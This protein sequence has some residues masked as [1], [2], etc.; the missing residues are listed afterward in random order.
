MTYEIMKDIIIVLVTAILSMGGYWVT[1]GSSYTTKAE[2]TAMFIENQ[3]F[4][5]I[6]IDQLV[7]AR[8]E[9]SQALKEN[10]SAITELKI[11]IAKLASDKR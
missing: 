3:K 7:E 6:E 11:A 4:T 8:K 1:V 5:Q 10:T 2:V 9:M